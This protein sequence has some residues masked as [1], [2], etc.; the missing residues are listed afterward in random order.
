M[1]CYNVPSVPSVPCA[2]A[3]RELAPGRATVHARAAGAS[4]QHTLYQTEWRAQAEASRCS[5]AALSRS[6][7]GVYECMHLD[8]ARRAEDGRLLA[9]FAGRAKS[10]NGHAN[11]QSHSGDSGR[12]WSPASVLSRAAT[13]IFSGGSANERLRS[14]DGSPLPRRGA[15]MHRKDSRALG[16]DGHGHDCLG[17]QLATT[18]VDEIV[19]GRSPKTG[20]VPVG[21]AGMTFRVDENGNLAR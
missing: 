9:D 17:R 18:L 15:G 6:T 16:V 13:S 14:D 2:D 8:E 4:L 5:T 3:C 10:L 20:T 11:G 19:F 7:G 1:P 21:A 12:S